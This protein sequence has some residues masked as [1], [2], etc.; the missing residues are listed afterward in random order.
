MQEYRR[1]DVLLSLTRLTAAAIHMAWTSGQLGGGVLEYDMGRY[2]RRACKPLRITSLMR[3]HGP[4]VFNDKEPN[5]SI[6][7]DEAVEYS[8]AVQGA[9][10]RRRVF[11]VKTGCYR[12][13]SFA[14][15]LETD[16]A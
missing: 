3:A 16:M 12:R 15:D 14:Y 4:K 7:P 13:D 2:L 5:T 8:A 6:N 1:L 11:T 10:H 9:S